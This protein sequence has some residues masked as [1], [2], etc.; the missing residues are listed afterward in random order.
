MPDVR[1]NRPIAVGLLLA[2]AALGGQPD[3]AAV[4]ETVAALIASSGGEAAVVWQPL[5]AE[6]AAAISLNADG[7]F[8]AASM[9][10]VPIMIELYRRVDAGDLKLD[11]TVVVTNRFKSIVDGSA[12]ELSIG[13]D[14]DAEVYKLAGRPI[15]YRALNEAMITVSSNLAAN[16]LIDRLDPAAIRRTM[17]ALG[18]SGIEVLRGVEDQKAFDTGLNN[19]TDAS[20]LATL[21]WKLGRGEVVSARASAEMVD[22]LA[23]QKFGD[24]IPAG[25][26]AGT[27]VA[28]KTGTITRI[29]HDGGIVYSRRPYVLVVLTRGLDA[30]AGDALIAAISKAVYPLGK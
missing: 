20:A 18:A 11:D 28:H 1:P 7:R 2:A 4:R 21:F 12:Y 13:D 6:R 10:K 3:V 8:H 5:D 19:T 26:P 25:L 17:A 14:S 15:A 23:R 30:R 27:R 22:V 29:R 24:G 16:I 9:M